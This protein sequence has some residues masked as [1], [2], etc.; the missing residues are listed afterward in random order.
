MEKFYGDFR[1]SD[2]QHDIQ[3]ER[4]CEMLADTYWAKNRPKESI[5]T[6][7]IHSLCFGV[8]LGQKQIGFARCVTDY[9]VLYYLADVV[10]DKAYRGQGLGTQ[11]LLSII[12]HETLVSLLGKLG[13]N[14][15]HSF[16]EKF[17]FKRNRDT[18]MCRYPEA[19][20]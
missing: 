8:Y 1:I 12:E 2:N 20:L 6:S 11:L 3:F 16:Y 19:T 14:D 10:I 5:K 9:S 15:A 17:G 4:V 18:S 7:I 13:T